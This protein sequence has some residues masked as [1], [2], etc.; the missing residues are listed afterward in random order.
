M[1]TAP[2]GS[3]GDM[4]SHSSTHAT[5]ST[6]G[7]VTPG[8]RL[9]LSV[10]E[11]QSQILQIEVRLL[12]RRCRLC[13][14]SSATAQA[15]PGLRERRLLSAGAASQSSLLLVDLA[16]K[17]AGQALCSHEQS[18]FFSPSCHDWNAENIL[19]SQQ[20]TPFSS[21]RRS[22]HQNAGSR[23]PLASCAC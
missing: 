11:M 6:A 13:A 17:P 21:P 8:R 2:A 16:A 4:G 3:R 18:A 1:S 9:A 12:E 22:N 7:A 14:T 20:W 10:L 23:W 19:H 15:K 5:S